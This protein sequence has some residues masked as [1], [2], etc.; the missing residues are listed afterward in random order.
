[1][2]LLD[3]GAEQ[4]KPIVKWVGGKTQL[5]PELLQHIPDNIEGAYWEPFAGG[6]ALFWRLCADGRL[7]EAHLCDANTDLIEMYRAVQTNPE[8]VAHELGVLME[9]YRAAAEATYYDTRNVWNFGQRTPARFI[10]LKQT[11]FNGLW[12]VNKAGMM[13]AS[14]GKYKKPTVPNL[15]ALRAYADLLKDTVL[16]SGSWD[17]CLQQ[18]SGGDV[19]YM[20]P[21]YADTDFTAYTAGGFSPQDHADLVRVCY[22]LTQRGARVVYSNR[23]TDG[24]LAMLD[25]VW[26]GHQRRLVK[27]RRAINNKG[28]GRGPVDEVIAWG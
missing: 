9:Q 3:M 27:A 13:N 16:Y 21:P 17:A 26:P 18:V 22:V 24:V 28:S 12:R 7:Q 1:M 11:S 25:E 5:L 10:F 8:L 20:D 15:D 6:A 19:V 23:G 2:E 4:M 14:W